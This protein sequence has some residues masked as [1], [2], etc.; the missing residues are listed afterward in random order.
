MRTQG[1]ENLD[2]IEIIESRKGQ[3]SLA[4]SRVKGD[5]VLARKLEKRFGA[6]RGIDRVEA[7]AVEGR[8]SID[9]DVRQLTSLPFFMRLQETFSS[10]F[11]EVDSL[12]LA[13]RL[14]RHLF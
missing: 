3:I 14:S 1:D 5:E 10:F 7:D 4:I 9:Y 2:G 12:K 6:I 13:A 11:P 8:V